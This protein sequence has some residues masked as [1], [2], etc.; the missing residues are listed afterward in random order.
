[1]TNVLPPVPDDSGG[2]DSGGGSTD[3][4][5]RYGGANPNCAQAQPF[6]DHTYYVGNDQGGDR[7]DSLE[8]IFSS[9]RPDRVKLTNATFDPSYEALN[10]LPFSCV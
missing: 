6:F 7:I 5:Q 2:D 1:M 3:Y 10:T 4:P 9:Y 8:P